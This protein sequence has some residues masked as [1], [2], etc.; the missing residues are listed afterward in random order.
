M[1]LQS[2]EPPLWGYVPAGPSD[3]GSH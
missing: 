3:S 2:G 1:W